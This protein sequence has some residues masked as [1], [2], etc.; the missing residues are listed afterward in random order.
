MSATPKK[1]TKDA[2]AEALI[3][4]RFECEESVSLPEIVVGKLAELEAWRDFQKVRLPVSEIPATIRSQD[5]SLK[6][7][8]VLEIRETNGS[9]LVKI[10]VNILSFHRLAPYPGWESFKP[11][12]YNVIDGLFSS[13]QDFKATRLGFRYI[14]IFTDTDH[15]VKNVR[16]LNYSVKVAGQ[17]LQEPQNLNYKIARS[18]VHTALVRIASSEFVS[19]PAGRTIDVLVDLDVFTPEGWSTDDVGVAQK[20]V[21]A[22]HTY[23]KEEFFKLFTDDMITKL[24]EIE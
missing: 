1:L 4:I 16:H 9:R 14:N 6:N 7:Q 23:E 12:I 3:D 8:P 10:G 17:D 5:P 11:E 24:V 22:A 13:F 15:G 21:E 20:W 19:G 2:I 18:N